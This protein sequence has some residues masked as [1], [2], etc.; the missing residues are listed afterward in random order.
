MKTKM[1]F[2]SLVAVLASAGAFIQAS[3]AQTSDVTGATA[4]TSPVAFVY[5]SRT[6]NIDGFSV[7]SGGKLTPVPGSPFGYIGYGKLSVS[8]H[9]LFGMASD[10][11][12]VTSFSIGSNGSIKKVDTFNAWAHEPGEG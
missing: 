12:K 7:S 5:V 4:A 2:L 6:K 1:E 10:G 11:S 9:F 8:R 3:P